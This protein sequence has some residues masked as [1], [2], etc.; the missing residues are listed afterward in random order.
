ME[1]LLRSGVP[2][3]LAMMATGADRLKVNEAASRG[4]Y[5]PPEAEGATRL[6]RE[7]DLIGLRLLADL[8]RL[9]LR[10]PYAASRAESAKHVLDEFPATKIININLHSDG[11]ESVWSD[12]I[13][14][15]PPDSAPV[16]LALRCNV[17]AIRGEIRAGLERVFDAS[18]EEFERLRAASAGERAAEKVDV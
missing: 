15:A 9:D 5:R 10:L 1:A 18:P 8:L 2:T 14:G 6:W 4:Y 11:A 16:T 3:R 13:G 12:A 17:E 7:N